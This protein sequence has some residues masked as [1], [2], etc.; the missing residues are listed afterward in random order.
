MGCDPSTS[1][2]VALASVDRGEERGVLFESRG[3]VEDRESLWPS[4]N[5]R[6]KG[7]FDSIRGERIK[8][9]FEWMAVEALYWGVG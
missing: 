6:M 4:Q 8:G 2:V 3:Y 7:Q 5:G 1:S 9:L